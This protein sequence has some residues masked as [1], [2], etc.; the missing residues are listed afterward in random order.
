MR[1]P[2]DVTAYELPAALAVLEQHGF[3]AVVER[4]QVGGQFPAGPERVVRQRTRPDGTVELL[5]TAQFALGQSTHR[6]K[7]RR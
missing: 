2:P 5:V 1:Q 7:R 4:V 6:E 3:P